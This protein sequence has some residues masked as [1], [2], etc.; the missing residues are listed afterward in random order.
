MLLDKVYGFFHRPTGGKGAEIASTILPNSSN[1][2]Q[3][4][5]GILNV[6]PQIEEGFI[7]LEVDVVSWLEL[8]DEI[9]LEDKGLFFCVS[10]D[11]LDILNLGNKES[12][13]KSGVF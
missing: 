2:G 11:T 12:D 3:F 9:I 4:G 1:E 10:D 8:L 7:V 6:Q 5:E 13:E